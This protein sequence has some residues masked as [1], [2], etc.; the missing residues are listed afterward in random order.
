MVDVQLGEFGEQEARSRLERALIGAGVRFSGASDKG[1]DLLMQ[2]ESPAPDP[3]PLHVA[4]QVKT[5]ESFARP[6]GARWRVQNLDPSRFRQWTRSKVPVLFVWVRPTSPAECYWALIKRDSSREHFTIGKR[7]YVTPVLR[8]DLWL[9]LA[10]EGDAVSV[11]AELLRPPLSVG[12]R[13]HAK[14]YYRNSLLG[15]H[16]INPVI[17]RVNFTWNGWRHLTRRGR[18]P[19]HIHQSLMLLP[20]ASAALAGAV[21]FAG[22]RRLSHVVRGQ[23]VVDTRLIALRG[24]QLRFKNRAPADVAVVV[25]E[26][27]FYPA[28]WMSDVRLHANIRRE[29]TFHS[30]YEKNEVPRP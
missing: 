30:I 2:F 13:L 18:R 4:V 25:R 9:E 5:G 24:V 14:D 7:A 3:Q 16:V 1:L 28:G 22:L 15:S 11:P 20:S 29:V 19:S 27:V 26:R 10:R 21:R 12:L 8:N 23:W 6:D 17:G